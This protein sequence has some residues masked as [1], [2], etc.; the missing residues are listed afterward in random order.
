MTMMM[1]MTMAM[2]MMTM[3]MMMRMIRSDRT[4]SGTS[5]C[6]AQLPI[7]GVEASSL[8][9]SR[10][11]V[12]QSRGGVEPSGL[13]KTGAGGEPSTVE[14]NLRPFTWGNACCLHRRGEPSTFH[15][16]QPS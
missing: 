2:M 15:Q 11:G 3:T 6:T 8:R 7:D 4:P 9:K 13:G 1:M 10:G 14:A 12:E 16:R 5:Q